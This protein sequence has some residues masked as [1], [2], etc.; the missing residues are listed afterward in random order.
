MLTILTLTFT[1]MEIVMTSLSQAAFIMVLV[2]NEVKMENDNEDD[3][4]DGC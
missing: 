2:L 3:G 4:D 1:L